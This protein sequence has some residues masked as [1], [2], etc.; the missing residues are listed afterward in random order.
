[1]STY[2]GASSSIA[3]CSRF[4]FADCSATTLSNGPPSSVHEPDTIAN[5]ASSASPF[6]L[7]FN[8]ET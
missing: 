2:P 8:E 3:V 7:V 6:L 1:M 4:M 5:I